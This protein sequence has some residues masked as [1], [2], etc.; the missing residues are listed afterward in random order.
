M[1]DEEG[2]AR[3][4]KKKINGTINSNYPSFAS[5]E[6]NPFRERI[7]IIFFMASMSNRAING[8]AVKRDV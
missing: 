5:R 4:G 6:Q 1:N 2:R 3:T 7:R 8:R